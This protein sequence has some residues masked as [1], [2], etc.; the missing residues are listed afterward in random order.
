[1]EANDALLQVEA[2]GICGS[3]VPKFNG[4]SA[5]FAVPFPLIMSREVVG[6]SLGSKEVRVSL[7]EGIDEMGYS[8]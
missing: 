1:M 6:E 8:A 7:R 4:I 3:D 5:P 2:V